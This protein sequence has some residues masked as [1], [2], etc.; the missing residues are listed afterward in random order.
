[1][2]ERIEVTAGL[3][4]EISEVLVNGIYNC[5]NSL[6]K[7]SERREGENPALNALIDSTIIYMQMHNKSYIQDILDIAE[8]IK[9]DS[10]Y[11]YSND[12]SVIIDNIA[13]YY[14]TFIS[15]NSYEEYYQNLRNI[16]SLNNNLIKSSYTKEDCQNLIKSLIENI[17]FS[18][19][20]DLSPFF[21]DFLIS[22]IKSN[23]EILE[24]S[25]H[26]LRH[27]LNS[28][29]IN[30]RLI[31]D[32]SFLIQ[33]INYLPLLFNNM[34]TAH[35]LQKLE[36]DEPIDD[37]S[38][39]LVLKK[40]N[41]IKA[42]KNAK[43]KASKEAVKKEPKFRKL[44]QLWIKGDWS[45]KGRGKYSQFAKHILYNDEIEGLEYDAIRNYI[46]KFDKANI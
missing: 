12:E 32:M 11:I 4:I 5:L 41:T 8:D 14:T 3:E 34:V 10:E 43:I 35:S 36:N 33:F 44:E 25:L 1:M 39:N 31:I 2:D 45:S 7:G 42:R 18:S 21:E 6:I 13:N 29:T 19:K 23:L 28:K 15:S 20:V 46:S 26:Y 30:N 24:L 38:F 40:I 27:L 37:Q 9:N 17:L 16:I 22:L